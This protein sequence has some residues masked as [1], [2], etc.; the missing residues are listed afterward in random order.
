MGQDIRLTAQ[1]AHKHVLLLR[2]FAIFVRVSEVIRDFLR[3]F[4]PFAAALE[5]AL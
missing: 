5:G 3:A 2:S 1:L 4:E